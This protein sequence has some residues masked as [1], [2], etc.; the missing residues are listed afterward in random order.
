MLGLLID[1]FVS[2]AQKKLAR[3]AVLARSGAASE[4]AARIAHSIKGAGAMAGAI[5]LSRLAAA[6]ERD[7]AKNPATLSESDA[8]RLSAAFASYRAALAEKGLV[9]HG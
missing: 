2:D 1:T 4:E 5:P 3:L 7:L 8:T 9:A 6:L